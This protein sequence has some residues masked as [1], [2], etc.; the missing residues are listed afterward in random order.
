M[1]LNDKTAQDG[2]NISNLFTDYFSSSYSNICPSTKDV[3]VTNTNSVDLCN[4][5]INIQEVFSALEN[6]N[7]N[8]STGPDGIQEIILKQ[9]RFALTVPLHFLFS[10]SLSSGTF[11]DSWKSSFVQPIFKNGVRSDIVNYRPISLMST[12][13]KLFELILLPKLN[14]FFSKLIIAEQFGFRPNTSTTSNLVTYYNY[15]IDAVEKGDQVD[16]IYTDIS[17]TFDTVNHAILIRKL[18]LMGVRGK[19]LNWFNSYI[20][21]RSQKVGVNGCISKNI[22]VPSGVP[23]GGHISPLLFILYMNDVGLVFKFT[24]FSMYADDLKLYCIIN[25]LEDGLRLQKDFDNFREWCCC[26]DLTLNVKKCSSIS[27]Y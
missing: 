22:S 11:P 20:S 5:S 21:F 13:P 19:I 18:E 17:K 7:Y 2:L 16:A 10:L 4:L 24:N 15:L 14:F 25:S 1:F 27:F 8:C 26:N 3:R 23:Q 9:C 6:C 12:I